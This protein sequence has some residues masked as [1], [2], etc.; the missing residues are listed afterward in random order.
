MSVLQQQL[1]AANAT[2]TRML[3]EP[4]EEYSEA[5]ERI[6]L[7]NIES[8]MNAVDRLERK[9]FAQNGSTLSHGRQ[10]W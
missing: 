7:R 5:G 10:I 2:L 8:Q 6:R 4:A 3:G 1:D 9:I